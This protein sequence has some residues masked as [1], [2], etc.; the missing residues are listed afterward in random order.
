M[1]EIVIVLNVIREVLHLLC[2]ENNYMA[3]EVVVK[4]CYVLLK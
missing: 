4:H 2:L 3:V 1:D